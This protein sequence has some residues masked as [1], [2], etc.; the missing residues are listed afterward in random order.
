MRPCSAS[1]APTIPARPRTR[2][3]GSTTRFGA[4]RCPPRCEHSRH[5]PRSARR[6]SC[7]GSPEPSAARVAPAVRADEVERAVELTP[8]PGMLPA[9]QGLEVEVEQLAGVAELELFEKLAALAGEAEEAAAARQ[10]PPGRLDQQRLDS[11]PLR[12][13]VRAPRRPP[14]RAATRSSAFAPHGPACSTRSQPEASGAVARRRL[15]KCERELRA[16]GHDH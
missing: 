15:A 2:P 8:E 16:G 6:A 7:E 3:Y 12:A 1:A 13:A 9:G 10:G 14:D 11:E 4:N 5:V